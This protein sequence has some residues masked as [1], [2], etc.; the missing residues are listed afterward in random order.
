M[1][2]KVC[3][4]KARLNF[5]IK[6][7]ENQKNLQKKAQWRKEHQKEKKHPHC[8][9]VENMQQPVRNLSAQL[10]AMIFETCP[11]V[12]NLMRFSKKSTGKREEG[13]GCMKFRRSSMR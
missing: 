1:Q 3:E 5:D 4:V 8:R 7:A 11:K 10:R 13:V 9:Q 6:N 12:K 2:Q